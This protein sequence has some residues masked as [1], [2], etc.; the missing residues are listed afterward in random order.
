MVATQSS[1]SF[2]SAL[3]A[4]S[5]VACFFLRHLFRM[6]ALILPTSSGGEDLL[7][8]TPTCAKKASGSN[9]L[10]KIAKD[11]TRENAKFGCARGRGQ[12]AGREAFPAPTRT[13][14]WR[15]FVLFV[16]AKETNM[17]NKAFKWALED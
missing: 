4:F 7:N 5:A 11:A 16:L 12:L 9:K 3:S 10:R 1:P 15:F 13:R 2:M 6:R 8:K 17:K 14:I